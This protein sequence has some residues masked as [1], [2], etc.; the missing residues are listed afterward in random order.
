MWQ[1]LSWEGYGPTKEYHGLF[2]HSDA[3]HDENPVQE[4]ISWYLSVY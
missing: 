1:E 3:I 2:Q 4:I